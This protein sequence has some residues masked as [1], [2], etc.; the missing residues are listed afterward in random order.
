M[1]NRENKL[2]KIGGVIFK[3]DG[4][5]FSEREYLTRFRT[6][7]EDADITYKL[8]AVDEIMVPDIRCVQEGEYIHRYE[9]EGQRVR[10]IYNQKKNR[11]LMKDYCTDGMHHYV[12]YDKKHMTYWDTNM[13][14]KLFELPYHLLEKQGV[15]LHA[16]YI[17]WKGRAILFTAPKQTGKSTQASLWKK[18]KNA[19]IV[20]GDRTIIKKENG[21]WMAYGSPYCG[22]SGICNNISAPIGAVVILSQAS[23][24]Q[25][26]PAKTME[27]IIAMMDGCTYEKQDKKQICKVT[28]V[29][30]RVISEVPFYRL[31]CLPDKSA[32][33][34][35]EEVLWEKN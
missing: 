21:Y 16:S 35:L 2:Y 17:I 23:V 33:E 13:M 4:P 20:N 5:V 32:V 19:E 7:N 24:N 34:L 8:D 3:Y 26:R 6:E 18:Y 1:Q 15:F 9:T 14:M 25:L 10:I 12:E 29:I 22:T 27:A 30:Q 11:I 31:A 28:D